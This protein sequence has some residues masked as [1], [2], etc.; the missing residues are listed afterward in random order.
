MRKTSKNI[1]LRRVS[2]TKAKNNRK[3]AEKSQ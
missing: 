2:E 1:D 3:R